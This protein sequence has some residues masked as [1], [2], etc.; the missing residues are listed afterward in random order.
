MLKII[1]SLFLI[2]LFLGAGPCLASCGPVL[3]CYIAATKN[4]YRRALFSY[5]VFSFGRIFV[6][7]VFGLLVGIFSQE[8][9]RKLTNKFN[10]IFLFTGLFIVSLGFL[11]ILGTKANF[12]FCRL[13]EDKLIKKDT[14]SIITL[15]ILFGITPCL[16]LVGILSYI[17]IV[18]KSIVTSLIYMLSFGMGTLLSPLLLLSIAAGSLPQLLK[19][20]AKL[21]NLFKILCGLI[22]MV[23]GF[24][25]LIRIFN[26]Q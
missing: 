24:Q 22:I 7:L 1:I 3:V 12:K 18:S 19:E 23:F 10:F 26:S 4:D 17:S 9:I 5:L 25:I 14:K 15:G 21:S 2:G 8:I 13:L 11:I 16:P 6:Y 20:H